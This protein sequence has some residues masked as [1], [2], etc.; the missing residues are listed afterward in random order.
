MPLRSII[1]G[2]S[3]SRMKRYL[4]CQESLVHMIYSGITGLNYVQLILF[5]GVFM[6]EHGRKLIRIEKLAPKRPLP[7]SFRGEG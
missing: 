7:I 4:F 5:E 1:P 3:G 2:F 6:G